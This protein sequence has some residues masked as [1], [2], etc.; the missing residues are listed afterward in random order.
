MK[1]YCEEL[2]FSFPLPY[3]YVEESRTRRFNKGAK[4]R[5]LQ[6]T[7]TRTL[8]KLLARSRNGRAMAESDGEEEKQPWQEQFGNIP[9]YSANARSA[10]KNRTSVTR[11]DRLGTHTE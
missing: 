1:K 6:Y 11:K 10:E 7:T 8:A 2:L 3:L 5:N 4:K 9:R